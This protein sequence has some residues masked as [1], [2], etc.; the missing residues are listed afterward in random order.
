MSRILIVEDEPW[1]GEIY[2]A[3]LQK[4]GFSVQL[5]TDGQAAIELIDQNQPNVIVL[6]LLLPGGNGLQLIHELKSHADLKDIPIILC[7]SHHVQLAEGQRQAYGIARMLKKTDMT[8]QL[9][10]DAVTEAIG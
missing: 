9:L 2:Q 6:D 1:L 4:A 8:P 5:V 7:S 10:I 3:S